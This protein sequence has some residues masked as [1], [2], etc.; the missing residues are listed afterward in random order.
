MH[1]RSFLYQS[2]IVVPAIFFT[3]AAVYAS[4]APTHLTILMIRGHGARKQELVAA[5][6]RSAGDTVREISS[7]QVKGLE[8]TGNGFRV[9]LQDGQQF[10]TEKIVFN[11]CF[12]IDTNN[13]A[14]TIKGE[15]H[16][17]F[18]QYG[19]VPGHDNK[20]PEFWSFTTQHFTKEKV[21]PFI[22][23]NKPGFLCIS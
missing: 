14:V 23:R 2:G 16:P 3:P 7:E 15:G 21:L 22:K 10:A 5:T 13:G 11:A 17:L 19:A 8:Y 12:A 18:V 4:T 1:R 6:F 20:L 9:M